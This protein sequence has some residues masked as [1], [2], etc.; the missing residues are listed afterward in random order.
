MYVLAARERGIPSGAVTLDDAIDPRLSI[1]LDF[2]FCD[3]ARHR[4]LAQKRGVSSKRT[5]LMRSP[6]M[7]TLRS[8]RHPVLKPGQKAR[9]IMADTFFIGAWLAAMPLAGLWTARLVIEVA[10]Q[11]P[12]HDF[13]IKL[14]PVRER[15]EEKF[16]WT[17]FHH[18]HLWHRERGLKALSPPKNVHIVQPETRLS[19]LLENAHL[20]LNIESYASY[21]AFA[22]GIPVIH[23]AKPC[24]TL[25]SLAELTKEGA[26]QYV[27]RAEDLA[28]LIKTNIHDE[29]HIIRQTAAQ[30]EFIK[31]MFPV[32]VPHL[33][34]F[35]QTQFA[36]S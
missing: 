3:D 5:L 2:A 25:D 35:A 31:R 9:I 4:E 13:V 29:G 27:S 16:A 12:E 36:T 11:M 15:P 18:L 17:G 10:R 7:P 14:H 20:L 19:E 1:G 28:K 8:E 32:D 6:R 30:Q 23:L 24:S 26:D 34:D 33:A 21:E 22:L